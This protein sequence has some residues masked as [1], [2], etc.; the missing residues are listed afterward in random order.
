LNILDKL[1]SALKKIKINDHGSRIRFRKGAWILVPAFSIAMFM[2]VA[3]PAQALS[4]VFESTA[5]AK[6]TLGS[7]ASRTQCTALDK[8][9]IGPYIMT[10]TDA[11]S[12]DSYSYVT[13][14]NYT[15]EQQLYE[16]Q[17][18]TTQNLSYSTSTGEAYGGRSGVIRL[19]SSGTISYA[20]TCDNHGTYGSAF[21]PEIWTEPFPA[22]ANQSISFD[23]AAAGGGDDYEA[24]G[25][26]VEVS[27][28]GNS[29]DYGSS[30]TSTLVSY[31][32]GQNQGWVTSSGTV[33]STGYYRFRF[34][35]GSY[36]ATGGQVLGASMYIDSAISVA[37]ANTITFAQ[38]SDIV[39]S[40]SN[41]TFTV[42]A[43]A[44][45]GL[46]VTFTSSTTGKCTVGSS[47]DS[48]GTSTATVTVLASQTGTCTIS[49]N[50]SSNN[51]YVSAATV[52]QSFTLLAGATAP[53]TSGGTSMS[54]T[55]EYGETLTAVDGTWGDGGSAVTAT[56]YQWQSC[57]PSSC[58]WTNISGATSST[59]VVGSG[60][61]AKQIRVAVTKT[62]S[63]GSLTANSAASIT[64]PALTSVIVE[65]LSD[66]SDSGSLRWAITTANASATINTIT[67]ASG[68]TGTITLTS[69]LP[70][71]TD[72][73]TIT[74]TGMATTI[75][76][77]NNLWRA[78]YNNGA[79][80][81]VIEDMTFK[82]GKNVSWN[83][84]LIYN[85][86]GTMTFNRIKISNH[87]SWAFYQ[88]G[89]GVTTFNNSQF[90]NNGYAITS[91]HG[92][93]PDTLSLTDTDYSNRIYV[94]GSTFTSN[95][96]GIRTERFVKINNS[97]FTD[98]TQVGAY[99]G[100][101][102]RQQVLNSTFTS[103]GT[104]VYFS[105]WIPT[106][107]TVGAGNQTV[108][109]NT[110]NGN[111]TAIQFANNWNDGSS[112]YNGVSANSFSTASGNTFG[113]TAQNTNNFSGSGYVESNNTI[114]AAYLNPV[115]NLTAVANSD[116]S[117]DLDWDASAAS[118]TSI[119][120]YSVSF[121]DLTVIGGATSG[122]WGVWTNQGTNYSLSTEMFSGSNPVTT[123]YGPVRFGI[124]AMT[125]GC[126]GIGT[127]SCTYGPE[128]TVDA[129]VLDPT[130]TATTIPGPVYTDP[131]D[132]NPVYTE[133]INTNPVY[134]EPIDT[135]P[136]YTEPIDTEPVYTEPIDTDPIVV[137]I[138]P[139]DYTVIDIED[140]EPITTVILDNILENTFTTD[141]EADE[142]GAVLDTLL[143]A[144]LTNAQFDNVLEAVFTE[145]VS[146]DVFTEALTTMLGA[147]I[148]SAQLTAVLDSAFSEDTS[149]EN[150][151][152]ALV[153]IFN[154]PLSSGDLNTIMSAVFDEDIS[155]ADT[156]T[157][158]GDLLE[159]NL[160]MSETKAIFDSV[161][162]DDLSDAETIELIVD[163]LADE[164][165]SELLNTVLGAVFDEEVSNE[166]LIETFTAV[167]GNELDA[168]SVGVIVDVLESDSITNDQVSQVVDLITGQEGGIEAGQSA[169]LSAS[170]KVLESITPD[171]ATEVFA[172]LDVTNVTPEQEA[173][174]AEALTNAPQDIKE[175]LEEEVD[176]YGDGFDDYV[177][178]GSQ[179]DV[180][181]R[182][183]LIAATTA[184]AAITAAGA[185][186]GGPGGSGGSSGGGNSNGPSGTNNNVAK[187]NEEEEMAGEIAGPGD[188]E[189]SNFTK[190]SIFKYY[191]KEG[192][193][194]REFNWL[195]FGKKLWDITA[196]LA[197]TF[198]G[199]VV[200]Y[201][202]LSGTTQTIALASTV[203]ACVV[204]YAHQLLKNDEE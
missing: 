121:Y 107:W 108:S 69:D 39:T 35:N 156:K 149:A 52:S 51:S 96:Y 203:T 123:G 159:T 93:T 21:G 61:V 103:N 164:L 138:P 166:V 167:L 182:R 81:I 49:A 125:A 63:I 14:K 153:S 83:G 27:A 177:A 169:E 97:Q 134:I 77:G 41:Q 31:G 144:E 141:I 116:G 19:F 64:V 1:S 189:D 20:N 198:A 65:N 110:F 70:A 82:Q 147:D 142:V 124:K 4:P 131:V 148:T 184:V 57:T 139:D 191:I 193:E 90:N 201:Y 75:I 119:Y 15:R 46:L 66:T 117:V 26:L 6:V 80:T 62:N 79:R 111:T 163:V 28:S 197:F 37:S 114:T 185:A 2:P 67:F 105:S 17:E 188:D 174:L 59:Y 109:G 85:A 118:N 183:T 87:S 128:V 71:I 89:G 204:H 3:T 101:L 11:T 98:N 12:G 68:N 56:T 195:G 157:V 180:G 76:D 88:G 135:E 78:I 74:G 194:M 84:G 40:S 100:G 45:S 145:D 24:Y 113:V 176:I 129:T 151:V 54:G 86:S 102:N 34:V 29:Y 190:N 50:S 13:D 48:G 172:A 132:T 192:I 150:M 122:G 16:G 179:V 25:Y 161:F 112:V 171:Q 92:G 47:T 165:T 36:D 73:V 94:N 175:A 42:S 158:L 22:T 146:A 136:V 160:S 186:T 32:R 33:P 8:Q 120:G 5:A 60:D 130:T 133:P 115:T 170:P 104:G 155:V 95:T 202:T 154:G 18:A 53:T 72:G 181:S 196:G 23:W 10:G 187:R 137:I 152:S 91:D 168:E 9:G 162:D 99:L 7:L 38:P 55:V 178:V 143:G 199:S 140:N 200:V 106:S 58:T 126:A 30:A 43:T 127:G 173:Q 44:T